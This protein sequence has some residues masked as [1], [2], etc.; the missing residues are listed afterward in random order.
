MA[1]TWTA[2]RDC[3][4]GDVLF[5]L[6]WPITERLQSSFL[7][8]QL[9]CGVFEGTVDAMASYIAGVI[10]ATKICC[11]YA[12]L[13]KC[14]VRLRAGRDGS[15]LLSSRQPQTYA[16]SFVLQM[17]MWWGILGLH[18]DGSLLL[19]FFAGYFNARK[20]IA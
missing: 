9:F 2:R 13:V 20:N 7:C 4:S 12:A 16:T 15:A 14:T 1:M 8:M 10:A 18:Q 3:A 5:H 19:F 11:I 17:F 6:L